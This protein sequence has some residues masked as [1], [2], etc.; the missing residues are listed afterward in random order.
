M[1]GNNLV[2]HCW[3][4][5]IGLALFVGWWWALWEAWGAARIVA[6]EAN[7]ANEQ[8]LLCNVLWCAS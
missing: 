4:V 2:V 1:P 3:L 8:C 7:V 5:A 6:E